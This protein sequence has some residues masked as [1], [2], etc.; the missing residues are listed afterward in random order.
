MGQEVREGFFFIFKHFWAPKRSWKISH[1]VPGKC[2][3]S[4][5][6]FVSR[7]VGTLFYVK[8]IGE[9]LTGICVI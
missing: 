4:P 5:G 6:F 3:K 2:W 7:R 1:G 9:K 8:C